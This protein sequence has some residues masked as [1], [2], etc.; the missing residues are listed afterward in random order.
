VYQTPELLHIG[1]ANE[2]V[3]GNLNVGGDVYGELTYEG[4]EFDKD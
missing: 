4:Q 3:L 1:A 2:V